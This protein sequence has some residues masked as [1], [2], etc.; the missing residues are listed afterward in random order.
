MWKL[1]PPVSART[2][3]TK[4]VTI[5]M[6]HVAMGMCRFR[7]SRNWMG[8]LSF[9]HIIRFECLVLWTSRHKQV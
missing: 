8:L 6:G 2:Q 1:T 9:N 5:R 3:R 4:L 7:R